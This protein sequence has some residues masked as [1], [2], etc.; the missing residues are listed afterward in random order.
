MLNL[1]TQ[2]TSYFIN[3]S[4]REIKCESEKRTIVGRDIGWKLQ[5]KREKVEM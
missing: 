4:L 2:S 3:H 5:E 1:M